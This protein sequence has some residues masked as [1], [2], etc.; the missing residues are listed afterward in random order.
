MAGKVR[1]KNN[2][3]IVLSDER[4]ALL[5]REI[6]PAPDGALS[7]DEAANRVFQGDCTAIMPHLPDG[8]AAMALLDPPYN[9]TKTFN[10]STFRSRSEDAYRDY[11][12]GWMP[13]VKR[14]VRPGGAVYLCCDWKCTAACFEVLRRHFIVRNRITWQREK[15]RASESNWKNACEDIWYAVAPPEDAAIFHADAVRM[16]RKVIAPYRENGRP[17]DW[18]EESGGKFRLTGASNFWDDISVP[19]WSMPENTDHP[20]QKPEKLIA[21]LIL[22]STDP[23]DLVFDPFSGS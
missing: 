16:K 4:K 13:F 7:P 12:A 18:S 5:A 10:Q 2:R 6:T 17:K 1:A 20:A 15:G 21:K 8:F 9:L 11:L 19:F 3:T 22:A 14:L 23:G